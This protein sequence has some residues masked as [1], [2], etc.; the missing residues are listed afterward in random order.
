MFLA[1]V[2]GADSLLTK[3]GGE[4]DGDGLEEDDDIQIVYEGNGVESEAE[5]ESEDEPVLM[6]CR[7]KGCVIFGCRGDCLDDEDLGLGGMDEVAVPGLEG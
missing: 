7:S 1:G 3:G 5:P 6:W 2:W 4:E